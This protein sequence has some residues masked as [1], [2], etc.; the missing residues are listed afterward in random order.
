[1]AA[2]GKLGSTS[3]FGDS[4]SSLLGGSAEPTVSSK[5]KLEDV[6]LDSEVRHARS[7]SLFI[8]WV[9]GMHRFVSPIVLSA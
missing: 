8:A 2:G 5:P 4:T 6:P 1:M 3:L 7:P 9:E